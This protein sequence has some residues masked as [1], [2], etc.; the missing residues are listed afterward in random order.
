MAFTCAEVFAARGD[1]WNSP[2]YQFH[3]D[4][5]Y[6]RTDPDGTTRTIDRRLIDGYDVVPDRA[7]PH[8]AEPRP[9]FVDPKPAPV[10]RTSRL[11]CAQLQRLRQGK[12][13]TR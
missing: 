1:E 7:R 12:T 10:D 9:T 13:L 4:D 5:Y 11:V 6:R 8:K 2:N 3:V